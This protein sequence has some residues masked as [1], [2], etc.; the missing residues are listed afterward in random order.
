M[1]VLLLQMITNLFFCAACQANCLSVY[2]LIVEIFGSALGLFGVIVGIFPVPKMA[3]LISLTAFKLE[4]YFQDIIK[5]TGLRSMTEAK[6]EPPAKPNLL[7]HTET[8]THMHQNTDRA[9][10]L[11]SVYD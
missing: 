7:T 5:I 11:R 6:E 4:I 10:K 1:V 9:G 8:N 2:M 3:V